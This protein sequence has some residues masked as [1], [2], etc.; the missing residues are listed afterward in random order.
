MTRN[1]D[2]YDGHPN[3]AIDAFT[4][5]PAGIGGAITDKEKDLIRRFMNW[6]TLPAIYQEGV[7]RF[8]AADPSINDRIA[9]SL[10]SISETLAKINVNMANISRNI[11][12]GG[13]Q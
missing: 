13:V 2:V 9:R 3:E 1:I 7:E 11:Y 4:K 12:G 6:V 8:D 5:D 10:E